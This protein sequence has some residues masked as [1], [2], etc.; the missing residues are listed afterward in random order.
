[1][2]HGYGWAFAFHT[3]GSDWAV[4]D[5]G[6][7]QS[8]QVRGREIQWNRFFVEAV[9]LLGLICNR[10]LFIAAYSYVVHL[11]CNFRSCL[12]SNSKLEE[13]RVGGNYLKLFV[14]AFNDLG[15]LQDV[16]PCRFK[17]L[18]AGYWTA[19]I[20]RNHFGLEIAGQR[21]SFVSARV[22]RVSKSDWVGLIAYSF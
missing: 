13:I 14:L 1:M 20:R 11:M 6:F 10:H 22:E 8:K 21:L 7:K 18:V 15:F 19:L 16:I 17:Q 3:K 4:S 9:H 5:A 2:H 12:G